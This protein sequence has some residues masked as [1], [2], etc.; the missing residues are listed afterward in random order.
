MTRLSDRVVVLG[1]SFAIS[2]FNARLF[3]ESIEGTTSLA[4]PV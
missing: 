2:S 3:V 4:M 1:R